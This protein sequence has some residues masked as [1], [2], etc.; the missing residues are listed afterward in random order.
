MG[1]WERGALVGLREIWR[2]ARVRT[3]R[4]TAIVGR[5]ELIGQAHDAEREKGLSGATAQQLANRARETER[6]EGSAGDEIG[7]DRS[8][9]WAA[10][11]RGRARARESCH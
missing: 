8:A 1:A 6:E 4:S 11:E 7:A 5:A 9:H 3:R 2:R 10:S